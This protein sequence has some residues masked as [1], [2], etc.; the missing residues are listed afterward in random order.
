MRLKQLLYNQL[1]TIRYISGRTK[2]YHHGEQKS[3][4]K[5]LRDLLAWQINEGGFNDMYYAMGL[6]L[7]GSDQKEYIGRDRFL[8]IKNT[9]ERKLRQIA[10]CEG[11]NYDVITKDKFYANS[12]FI[13]NGI[14]CIQNLALISG[15]RLIFPDGRQESLESILSFNN[16]FILKN[17][18]L[19][20]GE[21]VFLCRIVG[22]KVDING[23]IK[24]WGD[25]KKILKSKIWVLQKQYSSHKVFNKF[26][27]SALN[28]TR[29]VTILNGQEP[30]YLCGFQGFATKNA[31]IDTWSH[32]SVY[33]GIDIVNE[34]LREYGFTSISDNRPG[35]LTA[36][37]DSG[38][39]FKDC[40]V[41]F[42]KEA[43]DLCIRAHKILYFNFII[44]W[45][46]AITDEG[47]LIVE[48]NEKPGMNVAQCVSGGLKRNI[49]ITSSTI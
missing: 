11:L 4:L 16:P 1:L 36:H 28:T 48:A 27:S 47:P 12:I 31:Q 20:A 42:L 40:R 5:I 17:I 8:K 34:C 33:V 38:V 24:D 22:R 37:P 10:G 44:G 29:I 15:S 32:G 2:Q 9:T 45:D 30:E 41:P 14:P 7:A 13:A 39:L 25:F 3:R 23:E 46:V 43:V 21:G 18:A 19:E 26:N 35:I 6:H 49:F